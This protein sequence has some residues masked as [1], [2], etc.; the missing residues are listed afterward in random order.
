MEELEQSFVWDDFEDC[1]LWNQKSGRLR[2]EQLI[3]AITTDVVIASS[4]N[5]KPSKSAVIS[6]EIIEEQH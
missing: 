4:F 2:Q 5:E 1:Y 6:E 3:A